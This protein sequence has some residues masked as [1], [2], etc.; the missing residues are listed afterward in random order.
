MTS[1]VIRTETAFGNPWSQ[2]ILIWEMLEEV[3][4]RTWLPVVPWG[5]WG[6][7]RLLSPSP[8]LGIPLTVPTLRAGC[9]DTSMRESC[10]VETIWTIY[11]TKQLRPPY[12]PLRFWQAGAY[13]FSSCGHPRTSLICKFPC[14]LNLPPT[15][16]EWSASFFGLSLPYAYR[17]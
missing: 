5:G 14:L 16:L 2:G 8:V 11:V 12:K 15:N 10:V 7:L 17:G 6:N 4:E 1:R 3:I 9:K 13:S